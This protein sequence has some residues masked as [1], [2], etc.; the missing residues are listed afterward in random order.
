MFMNNT[1]CVTSPLAATV[2]DLTI[3]Y[4][5]MAQPNPECPVQGK[6]A[7]SVPPA[8]GARKVLGIYRD[9]WN[10][11]DARVREVCE[12]AVDHL[13]NKCG[14]EIIDISIP[15]VPEAQLAHSVICITEM[16]EQ[17]RRRTPNPADWLSL[18]GPANKVVMS[19]G[20]RTPAADFLKY[21]SLRELVMR[22][23]AFLFQKHPGLLVMTPTTPMPGWP[24]VPGDT[25]YGMSDTNKTV[26][27]MLYIFL[28][29]MTGTPA[30]SAPVGYLDPEQGEGQIPV[31]LMATGEWGSEEQ[32]LAWAGEAEEY[33]HE[34]RDG[35]RHRPK[36][37][38]DVMDLV[39]DDKET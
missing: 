38:L 21:N 18:V 30:L 33:L 39:R 11:A 23:L 27:N 5:V 9:W 15:Y 17:A 13:A 1:M 26:R 3:A 22:H 19:V 24:I 4:R 12:K 28:A 20:T 2:S 16:S 37:W 34:T 14:Y 6:F 8:P 31:G 29:N 25:T 10:Q 32:L 36:E 7:L 35:G